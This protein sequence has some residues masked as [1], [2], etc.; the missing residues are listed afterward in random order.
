MYN[1]HKRRRQGAFTLVELLIVIGIIAI[2]ASIA[3]PSYIKYQQK[4]KVTSFALPVS[5]ACAKDIIA[6]CI[7]NVSDSAVTLD[8]TSLNL[9]NCADTTVPDYNLTITIS[10]TFTCETDGTV[11]GGTVDASLGGIT[12]YKARC[13]LGYKGVKCEVIST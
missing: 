9:K 2:L 13:I 4:S 7:A 6:Y 8:I 3:L 5:N 10:G 1:L 12:A 11:S